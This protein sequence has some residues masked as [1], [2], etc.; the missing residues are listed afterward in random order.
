MH[1]SRT[2]YGEMFGSVRPHAE[3]SGETDEWQMCRFVGKLVHFWHFCAKICLKDG[4]APLAMETTRPGKG[5][6]PKRV[7][8]KRRTEHENFAPF[9]TLKRFR[10]K[11]AKSRR[12]KL[13]RCTFRRIFSVENVGTRAKVAIAAPTTWKV[14]AAAA[15]T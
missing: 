5:S 4:R 9:H 10:Y 6:G 3:N 7:A 8:E 11:N 14:G 13:T 2:N 1:S 15:V 12:T